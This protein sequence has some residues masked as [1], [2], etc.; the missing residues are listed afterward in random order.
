MKTFIRKSAIVAASLLIMATSVFN[1]L[2]Q[3]TRP[4]YN[5]AYNRSIG[6]TVANATG[7][8]YVVK[9]KKGNIVLK[10]TVKSDKT[11]F[12][13]IAKLSAGTYHFYVGNYSIQEFIVE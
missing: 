4:V 8:Q 6:I 9:D 10:G 7:A 3:D 11:F 13:P 5:K 12:I 2:A 1:V